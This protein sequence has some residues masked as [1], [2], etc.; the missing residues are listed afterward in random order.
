MLDILIQHVAMPFEEVR[1][2]LSLLMIGAGAYFDIKQDREIPDMLV[3]GSLAVSALMAL[4]LPFE[5]L[6]YAAVVALLVGV[7]GYMA[8]KSGQLGSADVLMFVALCLML[9]IHP[10]FLSMPVNVPFFFSAYIFASVLFILYQLISIVPVILEDPSNAKKEALIILVPYLI[11]VYF[12]F[13]TPI[14]SFAYFML[15]TLV[16]LFAVFFYAY[17]DQIMKSFVVEIPLSKAEEE[18]AAAEYLSVKVNRVITKDDIELLKK[19]RIKKVKI[20][21]YAPFLPFLFAGVVLGLLISPLS[22]MY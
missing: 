9:P 18:V 11:F 6:L 19:K 5:L 3:Y 13:T 1:I 8:Y 16:V 22:F 20:Y 7:F 21:K 15:F 10:S 14:F 2:V 17:K 12:Y 4:L